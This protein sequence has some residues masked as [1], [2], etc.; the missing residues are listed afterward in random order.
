MIVIDS[1]ALVAILFDEPER[2]AFEDIIAGAERCVISAVSAH[3]TA[4]VVRLRHG[5]PAVQRSWQLLADSEIDI[6]PFDELQV[7]AAAVAF[8]RYGKGINPRARLNLSDCA[9]YALAKT[10][11]AALLFKGGDF[12]QTDLQP[13]A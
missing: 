2:Q 7:R 10:L 11:N 13:C 9:T 4:T 8:D 5:V 6:I 12:T 1:S 3:E